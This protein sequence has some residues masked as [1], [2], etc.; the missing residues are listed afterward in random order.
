M[1][2]STNTMNAIF[3]RVLSSW[4]APHG[5]IGEDTPIHCSIW[6]SVSAIAQAADTS[7]SFRRSL[8]PAQGGRARTGGERSIDSAARTRIVF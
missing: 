4:F 7:T 6:R 1:E 2:R 8:P 5:L 3:F